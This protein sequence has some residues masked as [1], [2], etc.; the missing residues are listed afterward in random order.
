LVHLKYIV[1]PGLNDNEAD[2][3]GFIR[4]CGQLKVCAVYISK[5][6]YDMVPR[7]EHTILMTARM[8]KGLHDIGIKASLEDNAYDL[9]PS[10]KRLIAEKLVEL[11]RTKL[12]IASADLHLGRGGA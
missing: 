6:M 2:V 5:D 4:L 10:D 9:M 7:S 3:N 11:D 8:I 12:H 1:L